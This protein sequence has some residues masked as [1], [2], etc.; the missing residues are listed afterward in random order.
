MLAEQMIKSIE[1]VHSRRVIHRDIK[2]Q[3]F[4]L[5]PNSLDHFIYILDFGLAQ[6]FMDK[7]FKHILNK[8]NKGFAGTAR[9]ASIKTHEKFEQSR[10]DDLESLSYVL[11]YFLRGN[12]PWQNL[13]LKGE[14]QNKYQLIYKKKLLTNPEQLCQGLPIEFKLMLEHSRSIDF[15][16]K[17]DYALFKDKFRKLFEENCFEYDFKYDWTT[18]DKKEDMGK[19]NAKEGK[20]KV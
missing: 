2:P 19:Q 1:F 8:N 15:E 7:D 3:N 6:N 5:G 4:A 9:F 13:K 16:D 14:G 18:I 10:K 12:L 11:I 20:G 17:P